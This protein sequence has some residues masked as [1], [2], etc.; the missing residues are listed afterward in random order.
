MKAVL[1]QM[2]PDIPVIDIFADAP[3]GNPKTSAYLLAAYVA[4]F[5]AGT[6]L[7]GVV[8]KSLH[9]EHVRLACIVLIALPLTGTKPHP[10]S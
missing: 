9:V 6:V 8:D 3:V 5:P 7:L 1:Q 10:N 4:W 2:A